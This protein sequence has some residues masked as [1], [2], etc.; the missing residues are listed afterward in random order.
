MK[1]K[2]NKRVVC[3]GEQVPTNCTV[4]VIV[5]TNDTSR[6]QAI[7]ERIAKKLLPAL[8]ISLEQRLVRKENNAVE[9]VLFNIVHES[10]ND[11]SVLPIVKKLAMDLADTFNINSSNFFINVAYLYNT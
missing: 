9:A 4:V 1:K 11:G 8:N 2:R 5:I 6:W 10:H 3:E 7:S